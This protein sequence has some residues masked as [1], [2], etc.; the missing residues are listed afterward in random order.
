M[1]KEIFGSICEMILMKTF[2]C[3]FSLRVELRVS[4]RDINLVG[5]FEI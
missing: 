3:F 4:I 5:E 2:I 1:K